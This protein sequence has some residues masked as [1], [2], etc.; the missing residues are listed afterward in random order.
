MKRV[1]PA[2]LTVAVLGAIAWAGL[3]RPA[4][5]T[6]L[7][8]SGAEFSSPAEAQVHAVLL[9]AQDGDVDGYLDAFDGPIRDRIARA[10]E[11]QGHDSFAESLPGR[12][13][14]EESRRLRR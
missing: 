5:P 13:F 9:K 7:P 6:S 14:P 8:T 3:R 1:L 12:A 10:I 11:E 4:E 2:C